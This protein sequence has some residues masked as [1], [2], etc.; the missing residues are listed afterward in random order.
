MREGRDRGCDRGKERVADVRRLETIAAVAEDALILDDRTAAAERALGDGALE[1]EGDSFI[2]GEG[3]VN[4]RCMLP[5]TSL[6]NIY[7]CHP[8]RWGSLDCLSRQF[9]GH[10]AAA[11]A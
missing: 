5:S 4:L 8:A 10:R 11:Q 6:W 9:R 7:V 3:G 2:L 1:A